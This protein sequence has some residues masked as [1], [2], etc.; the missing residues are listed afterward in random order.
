[1]R[2]ITLVEIYSRWLAT[3]GWETRVPV[4]PTWASPLP[5]PG[6]SCSSYWPSLPPALPHPHRLA[7]RLP[8]DQASDTF[9]EEPQPFCHGWVGRTTWLIPVLAGPETQTI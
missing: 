6:Q 3:P 8:G 7:L 5:L 9:Q 2:K 1:M 4:W